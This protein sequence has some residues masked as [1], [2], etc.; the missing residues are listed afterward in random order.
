MVTPGKRWV[1]GVMFPESMNS[2]LAQIN[3]FVGSV[4]FGSPGNIN[5]SLH[6][7]VAYLGNTPIM[8]P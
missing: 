1:L 3:Q 7:D 8:I 5:K 2:L 4:D 6:R